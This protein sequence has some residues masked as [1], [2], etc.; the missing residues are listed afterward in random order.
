M[1]GDRCL[2]R[3]DWKGRRGVG[4]IRGWLWDCVATVD[5]LMFHHVH[6]IFCPGWRFLNL[7]VLFENVSL[8][9]LRSSKAELH[10]SSPD[11]ETA[12]GYCLLL[13]IVT[14]HMVRGSETL[15]VLDKNGV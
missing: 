13:S 10:S 14:L 8:G 15:A 6:G 9:L 1:C 7:S 12:R 11:G 3:A 2:S 5:L 4:V